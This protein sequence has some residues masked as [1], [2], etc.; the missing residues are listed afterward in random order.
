MA[1]GCNCRRPSAGRYAGPEGIDQGAACDDFDAADLASPARRPNP[2]NVLPRDAKG[3]ATASSRSPR[4]A[5]AR[6]KA[7][8]KHAAATAKRVRKHGTPVEQLAP[9]DQ[10]LREFVAD[11][12]A[13]FSMMRILR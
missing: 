1:A 9:G 11:L 2:M 12:Y 8:A 7:P 10:V 3:H 4:R 13:A 6:K 5:V